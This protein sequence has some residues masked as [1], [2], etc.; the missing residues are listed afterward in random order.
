[1]DDESLIFLAEYGNSRRTRKAV[2]TKPLRPTIQDLRPMS[3]VG[4]S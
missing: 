3:G 2:L 1:M 4:R